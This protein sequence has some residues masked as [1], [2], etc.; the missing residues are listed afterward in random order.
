MLGRF[1]CKQLSELAKPCSKTSENALVVVVIIV[2]V[3]DFNLLHSDAFPVTKCSFY[4]LCYYVIHAQRYHV[5]F[6]DLLT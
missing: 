3:R 4:R 6:A 1:W 5:V 2:C